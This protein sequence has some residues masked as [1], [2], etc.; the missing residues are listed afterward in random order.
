MVVAECG[1]YP[2]LRRAPSGS[3]RR[4]TAEEPY[5]FLRRSVKTPDAYPFLRVAWGSVPGCLGYRTRF[6]A[7]Q[8][9]PAG[10][11]VSA[12]DARQGAIAY[13]FLRIA[14]CRVRRR[15]RF[16]VVPYGGT[17]G[18]RK[19]KARRKAETAAGGVARAD[20][21]RAVGRRLVTG[22][23]HH[24]PQGC[25]SVQH[26]GS[27]KTKKPRKSGAFGAALPGGKA[28]TQ[29]PKPCRLTAA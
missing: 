5:P 10:V 28:R 1:S 9:D 2:F 7:K 29:R 15:T 17:R 16:C 11:P 23:D 12:D 3:A 25:R 26:Q 4:G 19:E 6:C 20:A 14:M 27:R 18:Q 21:L 24:C 8:A 13:P 22:W